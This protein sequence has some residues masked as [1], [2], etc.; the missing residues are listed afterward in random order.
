MTVRLRVWQSFGKAQPRIVNVIFLKVFKHLS[1]RRQMGLVNLKNLSGFQHSVKE[2]ADKR[3]TERVI[4]CPTL[5]LGRVGNVQVVFSVFPFFEQ[6]LK[7]EHALAHE[8]IRLISE[9]I[10]VV[11]IEILPPEGLRHP[12]RG[13]GPQEQLVVPNENP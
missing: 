6:S 11:A 5:K 8:G 1:P 3:Q 7:K 13:A 4:P 12:R 9:E 2:I 10:G